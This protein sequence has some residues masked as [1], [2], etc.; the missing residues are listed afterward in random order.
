VVAPFTKAAT[1][2]FQLPMKAIT[3]ITDKDKHLMPDIL[4]SAKYIVGL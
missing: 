3:A 2:G 1:T 4:N